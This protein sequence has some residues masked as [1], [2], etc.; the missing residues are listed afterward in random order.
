MVHK[1][2]R[3]EKADVKG[4]TDRTVKIFESKPNVAG[5]FV[6]VTKIEDVDGYK[7]WTTSYDENVETPLE[8][9][10]VKMTPRIKK[11]L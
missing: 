9:G 6:E 8:K 5:E 10:W 11:G 3:F 1:R 4:L 7:L 2:I